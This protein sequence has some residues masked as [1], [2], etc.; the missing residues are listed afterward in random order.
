MHVVKS[1]RL[2]VPVKSNNK[3]VSSAIILVVLVIIAI[4]INTAYKASQPASLPE[5]MVTISQRALEEQYGLRVNLVAITAAGGMVDL[6][7][8][9]LDG[10]KAQ[11]L[12]QDNKN[13]PALYVGDGD[14]TLN[15]P[16]DAKFQEIKFEDGGNLFLMFPN[17]GSAVRRGTAINVLFGDIALEPIPAK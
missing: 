14:I 5:G 2:T 6:R 3:P 17:S 9:I 15:A 13:F 12:L 10:E 11:M 1:G 8:K 4:Y 16:E 7:L